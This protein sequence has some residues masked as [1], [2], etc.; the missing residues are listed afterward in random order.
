MSVY[1]GIYASLWVMSVRV[2]VCVSVYEC[3]WCR[4]VFL[5]FWLTSACLYVASVDFLSKQMDWVFTSFFRTAAHQVLWVCVCLCT[6]EF[7]GVSCV[8]VCIA[9]SSSIMHI[10]TFQCEGKQGCRLCDPINFICFFANFTQWKYHCEQGFCR[11]SVCC[12]MQTSFIF[13]MCT[14]G[15]HLLYRPFLII[16]GQNLKIYVKLLYSTLGLKAH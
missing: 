4:E 2:C 14:L 6:L 9:Q 12:Y 7:W 5:W 8:S 3:V 13:Y 10:V 1:H 11:W 15:M 16:A